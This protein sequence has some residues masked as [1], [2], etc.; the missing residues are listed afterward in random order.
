MLGQCLGRQALQPVERHLLVVQLVE[1]ASELGRQAHRLLVCHAGIARQD[2]PRQQQPATQRRDGRQQRQLERAVERQL[3]LVRLADRRQARQEQR[4][5]VRRPPERL[6][7]GEAG[8]AAGQQQEGVGQPLPIPGEQARDQRRQ[9]RTVGV[10][11]VQ[12][13]HVRPA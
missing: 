1:K 8:A 7:G 9:E 4:L 5:T 12:V 11:G 2:Q 13:A 6:A 3:C 10:D